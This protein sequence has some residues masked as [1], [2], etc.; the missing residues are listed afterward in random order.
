[1]TE[2]ALRNKKRIS[3]K[4]IFILL[5][6]V[7]LIF[8]L[9]ALSYA[10]YRNY[11]DVE[12]SRVTT[13]KIA[14][15][16]EG[17]GVGSNGNVTPYTP[18][19]VDGNTKSAVIIESSLTRISSYDSAYHIYYF[20][21][22]SNQTR[23]NEIDASVL[24][25]LDNFGISNDLKGITVEVSAISEEALDGRNP[26]NLS[27]E[28]LNALLL[29]VDGTAVSEP[30]EITELSELGVEFSLSA[31]G[32]TC[33]RVSYRMPDSLA[34]RSDLSLDLRTSFCLANKNSLPEDGE[35]A[36]Y[37]AYSPD[38][39]RS[40]LLHSS[41][42]DK[43]AVRGT[44]EII[45]DLVISK[46]LT[47]DVQDSKLDIRG[48]LVCAYAQHGRF[49]IDTSRGGSIAVFK[50]NV[51]QSTD[52]GDV[53]YTGIG[54]SINIDTPF[55]YVELI[56]KNSNDR[57]LG[58]I[59]V[60]GYI[61]V[62][63]SITSAGSSY[64]Q[65]FI[66][67]GSNIYP[68]SAERGDTD[69]YKELLIGE[70]T[71]VLIM[72][73]TSVGAIS[74][75]SSIIEIENRGTIEKI[76]LS[77]MAIDENYT[78]DQPQIYINNYGVL[79]DNAISLPAT[80]TSKFYQDENGA[81][82]GNT[83]IVS[84]PGSAS[85]IV[86]PE[87]DGFNSDG[88]RDPQRDHIEY[89]KLE[90]F[91]EKVNGRDDEIIVQYTN[92][93]G[94][95]LKGTATDIGTS[96]AS[97]L[98]YY[99]GDID[100]SEQTNS[101]SSS[102]V[103]E[104][105]KIAS[106]D[107]LKSVRIVC[108]STELTAADY[109]YIKTMSGLVSL[110][111]SNAASTELSVPDNAFGGLSSLES[112]VMSG[113]DNKWGD[114][115]FTGTKVDEVRLP[116]SLLTVNSVNTLAG[117][118][119]VHTSTRLVENVVNANNETILVFV[120]DTTTLTAYNGT[121]NYGRVFYEAD[122]YKTNTGDYFLNLDT[123]GKTAILSAFK[124]SG[125]AF[126]EFD[127]SA[128][129][130]G[131]A[132]FDFNFI[133]VNGVQY[134]I[135][136]YGAY[137]F[138]GKTLKNTADGVLTL[139]EHVGTVGQSAFSN[140]SG[141]STLVI[142][143]AAN[144]EDSAFLGMKVNTINI[145]ENAYI[146]DNAFAS[147]KATKIYAPNVTDTG[148]NS[149]KEMGLLINAYLPSLRRTNEPFYGC[150]NIYRLDIAIFDKGTMFGQNSEN[151]RYTFIH[152]YES[153]K[154]DDYTYTLAYTG[155]NV[156]NNGSRY[157]FVPSSFASVYANYGVKVNIGDNNIDK[158]KEF[159]DA[160]DKNTVTYTNTYNKNEKVD[161]LNPNI[162]YL[163]NGDDT[164]SIVTYHKSSPSAGTDIF[165]VPK[166][167]GG[168]YTVTSLLSYSYCNVSFKFDSLEIS[169]TIT[170]IGDYAFWGS[171]KHIGKLDL[172]NVTRIGRYAFYN[173]V[174]AEVYGENVDFVGNYAFN[175]C[176]SLIYAY[177][178][179]WRSG[180]SSTDAGGFYFNGCS[181][182]RY[183]HLGPLDN[184][185]QSKM[186][187]GCS[188]L[189]TVTVDAR[190]RI[191]GMAA[192]ANMSDGTTAI[193]LIIGNSTHGFPNARQVDIDFSNLLVKG[194]V[195]Y[196]ITVNN[197]LYSVSL[198][199][200]LY[201]IDDS[202]REAELL[203]C[204]TRIVNQAKYV[205]PVQTIPQYTAEKV[206]F[207][208][209][210]L[211]TCL[212][213]ITEESSGLPIKKFAA[214]AYSGVNFGDTIFNTGP[215]I[216]AV[217]SSTFAGLSVKHIEL[218]NVITVAEHAFASKDFASVKA[219][220][221]E[222]I[223]Q[224]AF[225]HCD[226]LVSIDLPAIRSLGGWVFWDCA[227]LTTVRFGPDLT[228]FVKGG[229][230]ADCPSLT[231]VE[232]LSDLEKIYNNQRLFYDHVGYPGEYKDTKEENVTL[233]VKARYLENASDFWLFEML[234][235]EIEGENG[236]EIIEVFPTGRNYYPLKDVVSLEEKYT[237]PDGIDYYYDVIKGTTG[238]EIAHISF[239][240][241]YVMG[242]SFAFPSVVTKV[243][244][245][246]T[247]T[248]YMV[249][250]LHN[251][252]FGDIGEYATLC[253]VSVDTITLP[254]GIET[255][256]DNLFYIPSSVASIQLDGSNT[257]Y[258]TVNGVV[259]SYDMTTLIF[260]PTGKTDV[261]FVIPE[262]VTVIANG[263]FADNPYIESITGSSKMIIVGN[264]F[265][266]CIA[267]ESITLSSSDACAFIGAGFFDGCSSLTAIYVPEASIEAYKNNM[268][269][270]YSIR[271]I[272]IAIQP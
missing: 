61:Y 113:F 244:E 137:S 104:L 34:G 162:Y 37:V 264:V 119:Y 265:E 174:I 216:T 28:E 99:M 65:G 235:E 230:L 199:E 196:S 7:V 175:G 72:N 48:N 9:L 147:S 69:G 160:A 39:L 159:Y 220:K 191:L 227:A 27:D 176:T 198:P 154:P 186:F 238:A 223:G 247:V 135:V 184:G 117:I 83:R 67:N 106:V 2:M 245:N 70:T 32:F 20:I 75:I 124:P 62:D 145:L 189:R 237:A 31:G 128:E 26:F 112:V 252:V 143:G 108:L 115:L 266:N 133:T 140:V 254:N 100:A 177:L 4:A 109:D 111:L 146:G 158:I 211:V 6:S 263:A 94:L 240:D 136:E 80:G 203:K 116:A 202:G 212:D 232:I 262:S 17:Y 76:D 131:A 167:D 205:V 47:I 55:G 218:E 53:H 40:A 208:G 171:N 33:V 92:E 84:Q 121:D 82:H 170:E 161:F 242:T 236:P 268:M 172:N 103:N 38:G 248:T 139:G 122:R 157:L 222:V 204:N 3:K 11:V 225:S 5:F 213:S 197:K 249:T 156:S 207:F 224:E 260:Y 88:S 144:I 201:R 8:A 152:T 182:L 251:N 126:S 68:I 74:G 210:E 16:I 151:I 102:F 18:I 148:K 63:A 194:S 42:G 97:L 81:Y 54:G 241:G 239:P 79:T 14:L 23:A 30:A 12:G 233:V 270:D 57:T 25:G 185:V 52:G 123:M 155:V 71:K 56:G 234:K 168:A 272:I 200:V 219:N 86:S 166:E 243:N 35:Y 29:S 13:G 130:S 60:E 91:I 43:I 51:Q 257:V 118:K 73:Y 181:S 190:E 226:S 66:V 256:N 259:Y 153:D 261:S 110:D 85:M 253:G 149:F 231:R 36:E 125:Y 141:V 49:C 206:S 107:K 269:F 50:K 59:Y 258:K 178:P 21:R 255:L 209:H 193:F 78:T 195:T 127:V 10:W 164:V 19:S 271:D 187:V 58:D 114:N 246:G 180:E 138:Y 215:Y 142:E 129:L 24:V 192:P 120:P 228:T 1:M 221:L 188:A 165:K 267:L 46:P 183:V 87:T 169:S 41:A 98:G 105:L 22:N 89:V 179:V 64:G 90:T 163:D 132:K 173:S 96:L 134:T 95:F 101:D 150:S 45:G 77:D 44:M 217:N 15:E 214:N 229:D 93:T 250:R